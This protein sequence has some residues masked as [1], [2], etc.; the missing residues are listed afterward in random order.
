MKEFRFKV[1]KDGEKLCFFSEKEMIIKSKDKTYKIYKIEGFLD[2]RPIFYKNPNIV[3][4]LDV[5]E[6]SNSIFC[7]KTESGYHVIKTKTSPEGVV[8]ID[9]SFALFIEAGIGKIEVY[10]TDSRVTTYLPAMEVA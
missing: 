9:N 6:V 5:E 2:G 10:D 7:L 3:E 4:I 1:L 8:E